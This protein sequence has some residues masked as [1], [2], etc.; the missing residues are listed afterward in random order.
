M[1]KSPAA[2]THDAESAI[3]MH[4]QLSRNKKQINKSG[5]ETTDPVTKAATA[6]SPKGKR[7]NDMQQ[8]TPRGI[9]PGDSR[10]EGDPRVRQGGDCYAARH[11]HAWAVDQPTAAYMHE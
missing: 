11:A 2:L 3:L 6:A 1:N 5:L 7:P 4:S 9:G 8:I 10:S